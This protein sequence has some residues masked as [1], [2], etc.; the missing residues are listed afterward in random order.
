[1]SVRGPAGGC[2]RTGSAR[3]GRGSGQLGRGS[4]PGVTLRP[5]A[6]L[7]CKGGRQDRGNF[8]KNRENWFQVI[9]FRCAAISSDRKSGI[10]GCEMD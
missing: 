2:Q 6:P 9:W 4:E 5:S 10:Q 1:V 7:A 8:K 3:L